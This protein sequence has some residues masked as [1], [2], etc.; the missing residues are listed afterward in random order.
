MIKNNTGKKGAAQRSAIFPATLVVLPADPSR[1]SI[2][3]SDLLNI[4]ALVR[5]DAKS[6]SYLFDVALDL[7]VRVGLPVA[8]DGIT[9]GSPGR[10]RGITVA[11]EPNDLPEILQIASTLGVAW[12]ENG[13]ETTNG[14]IQAL[15]RG[16]KSGCLE[17][18][19]GP[20]PKLTEETSRAIEIHA[21]RHR[22]G[23]GALWCAVSWFAIGT[24]LRLM[25]PWQSRSA[26]VAR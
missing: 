15:H 11:F 16:H 19:Y 10:K 5:A 2:P 12:G 23:A 20:V 18:G 9:I 22:V 25:F 14:L 4:V 7:G 3:P 13:Y 26:G 21:T 6:Q 8:K 24:L 17:A 1:V